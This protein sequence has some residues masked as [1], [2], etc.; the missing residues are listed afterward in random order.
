M[1]LFRNTHIDF[2][3]YKWICIGISWALIV[4]GFIS[5]A[6]HHGLRLGIDFSGGTQ[7]VLKF[8]QRPDPGKIEG[9][10][11]PLGLGL[12]GVQRY[13]LPEKNEVLIK[14]KQQAHEGRDITQEILAALSQ[15][16][17]G[18]VGKLDANQKGHDSI[19]MAIAPADPDNMAGKPGDEAKQHYAVVGDAIVAYR[20]QIGLFRSPA[21]F[22]AI[23]DVSPAVKAWLKQNATLGPFTM[24]SADNVGPQVGKDLRSK[25]M[26]A[27]ILSTLAMLAYIAIRFD[28][29]FGVGAIVAIIHDTLI[30]IGLLSIFDREITLVVVAAVLTL[31][32]YSMN[33]TVVVYD[34]IR[35]NMRSNR[36]D[37]LARIINDSINQTLSRTVMSS[38]L[39]FLVVVAL[40][41]LGGEVLNTFALTLLIGII[42]GTYSSIY[43]AAPIVVIWNEWQEKGHPAPPSAKPT[44]PRRPAPAARVAA[45]KPGRR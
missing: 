1:E 29:K 24:L 25:A 23:P 7:I 13:D 4:A 39:T 12:E 21:D 10:L 35:E 19:A 32:G 18:T 43:V 15:A 30:T 11:K 9:I 42:V 40:F 31:V 8:A 2:L 44:P 34:R 5:I 38:G 16:L 26:W 37:P 6:A 22:D 17:G 3:R 41:F 14:V 36:R 20:S 45:G 33:D 27:I 28:I